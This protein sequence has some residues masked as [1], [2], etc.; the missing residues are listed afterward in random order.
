MHHIN[1]C[2]MLDMIIKDTTVMK[3][4]YIIRLMSKDIQ[5]SQYDDCEYMFS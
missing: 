4:K 5:P 2:H 3:S 1:F